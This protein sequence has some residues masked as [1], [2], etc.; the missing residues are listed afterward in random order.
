MTLPPR[1]EGCGDSYAKLMVIGEAPGINEEMQRVP[2]VGATGN[3]LS[4]ALAEHGVSIHD[5]WRTN[6]V[7][8]R[9]PDNDITRLR[10][11]GVKIEDY[12][13]E[14][15]KEISTINPNVILTVGDTALNSVCNLKGILKWR[16]SIVSSV[17]GH[18]TVPTIHPAA[19]FAHGDKQ[20]PWINLTFIKKDIARAVGQSKFKEIRRAS[21]NHN[22][23]K[24]SLDIIRYLDRW[25]HEQRCVVDVESSKTFPICIGVAHSKHEAISIQTFDGM[26][27]HELSYVWKIIAEYFADSKVNLAA[28]NT[29]FDQKRCRQLGLTWHDAWMDIP[30]AWHVLYSEM[31][32]K[33]EFA[34]SILTEIPY[35]KNEG[36]EY[37]PKKD[38]IERLL[39]YNAQDCTTEYECMELILSE[40]TETGLSSFFFDEIMP[41]HRLYYDMEDVGI[42][43]D[44]NV[45]RE[46][47]AKYVAMRK[48]Q[49]ETLVNSIKVYG[50]LNSFKL[51]A[52]KKGE[53]IIKE[54]DIENLNCD[55]PKQV[56][57]ILYGYL[58]CPIRK[59]TGEATLKALAN[60]AVKDESRKNI[61]KGILED[62]KIGKTI[63][64]YLDAEIGSYPINS[65]SPF[66][67]D[68]I[69]TQVNV[70]GTTSGRTSTSICKPPV[71]ITQQGL[72]LQTMT[73]HGDAADLRSMFI[74]DAGWS[75]IEPDL[76]SAEDHVVAVLCE[77]WDALKL[78]NKT[79]FIYNKHGLKDDRHTLTTMNVAGKSFDEVT[80]YDRQTGKRT[81]HS[82]NYDVGKHQFML[83][84]GKYGIFLSEWKCGKLLDEFHASNPRIRRVF[85]AGIQE[86]LASNN[87]TLVSPHGRR[88]VF[89]EKWGTELFKQSYSYI[90]QATVS[91]AVK[92]AMVRIKRR[93]SKERFHFVAESHDSCLPLVR[94]DYVTH[95][96]S[97]I[98]EE[99]TRPINF[100]R[101][102]LSRDYNLI[103][104]CEIKVG[105]RWIDWSE[106]FPD[107]M[108][109]WKN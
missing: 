66:K 8:I 108:K 39:L 6:V 50:N 9:P 83:T 67:G 47:K 102:T 41:L 72:A 1:V 76:S 96:I 60:N 18:K 81:R 53:D 58:N 62:R 92:F 40:L 106:Q 85:H 56:A 82:G 48:T 84:L 65:Y 80:D 42:L 49:K 69:F 29:K 100:K 15:F 71:S 98:R 94:D 55:S 27:E 26:S 14:L 30:M 16:G 37:N 88:E 64:T 99:M 97:V 4:E 63:G 52:K 25:R 36:K 90:P 86:A 89:F 78:L 54:V 51:K 87:R 79:D 17:T 38:K 93:L 105:K 22:I 103:I 57:A 33:L 109:K 35:Y 70:N 31:P 34:T 68:R 44:Q 12:H 24:S 19:L 101:C 28:W 13:E 104:P 107:G 2:F 20:L 77:D 75:F 10:E 74:A 45:K 5:V 23:A 59:D 95:A 11:Y 91:D 46:L 32:K 73:K 3:V 21:K 43:Q 7:K 61:I